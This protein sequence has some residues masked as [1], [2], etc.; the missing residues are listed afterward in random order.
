MSVNAM[1]K[2]RTAAIL[3]VFG[4]AAAPIPHAVAG[5]NVNWELSGGGPDG[6]GGY[7]VYVL[8]D[9]GDGIK[10]TRDN[11]KDARADGQEAADSFNV[12]GDEALDEWCDDHPDDC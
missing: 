12:G 1:K 5:D 10:I 7:S 4:T 3:V 8:D 11:K 6:H 9:Q 2:L